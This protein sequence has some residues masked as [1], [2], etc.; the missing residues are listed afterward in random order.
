[1]SDV[2]RGH[3]MTDLE[4]QIMSWREDPLFLS[5]EAKNQKDWVSFSISIPL[6]NKAKKTQIILEDEVE[7]FDLYE[8]GDIG[9]YLEER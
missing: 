6:Y 8:L 1:M 5:Q 4:A 7:W 3:K 2:I 9:E